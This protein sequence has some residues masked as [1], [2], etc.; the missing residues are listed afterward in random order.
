MN[1]TMIFIFAMALAGCAESMGSIPTASQL[2]SAVDFAMG[3]ESL[4]TVNCE[5]RNECYN[6]AFGHTKVRNVRCAE[7]SPRE[8]E[9]EYDVLHGTYESEWKPS[10]SKFE[11]GVGPNGKTGW[12]QLSP[13]VN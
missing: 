2:R 3:Q 1:R 4:S 10:R 9:C 7:T 6:A 12:R 11:I 13:A 5:G 8:A